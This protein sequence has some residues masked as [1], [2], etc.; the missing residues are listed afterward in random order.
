VNEERAIYAGL[1]IV[2]APVVAIAMARG[3]NI[4][5]TE[6]LA[7][8]CALGGLIGLWR[9]PKF[10]KARARLRRRG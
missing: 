1:V 4:G 3:A 5:A 6:T 8:L 2:G 10:P 7:G 9:S